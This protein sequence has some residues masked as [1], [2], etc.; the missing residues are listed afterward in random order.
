[1]EETMNNIQLYITQSI[2][3]HLF[4]ARIMKEHAIFLQAGFTP[5]NQDFSKEAQ[6]FQ[7]QFEELLQLAVGLSQVIN[8]HNEMQSQDEVTPYTL[9]AEMQTQNLTGIHINQNI[10]KQQLSN[11]HQTN[12]Q[13]NQKLYLQVQ[14]INKQASMLLKQYISYKENLI[15]HVANYHLFT[16]NYPLLLEHI[17]REAKKYDQNLSDIESG[18]NLNLQNKEEMEMFW[19]QIMMEHA[20]FIRG[21]LDP[22]EAKLIQISNQF[23]KAY[24]HLLQNMNQISPYIHNQSLQ[25]TMK[26]KEFKEAGTQGILNCHIKSIILP[27]LA[28]HV[29]REANHYILLLQTV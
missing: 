21:L 12:E 19:N 6:N 3:L 14:E 1:M 29:L 28:D 8:L 27:L 23:V 18:I 5:V 24:S 11:N 10:T 26:L 20:L 16:A 25:E 22:S 17:L 2:R 9:E 4:S 13:M 7:H 15:Q